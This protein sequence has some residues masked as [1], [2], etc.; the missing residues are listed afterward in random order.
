MYDAVVIGAGPAGA[1]AAKTVAENGGRVL[2]LEKMK[3]PRVK[4]CSGVLIQKTLDLVSRLYGGEIPDSVQCVPA[5]QRGM[6]FF[7][8][9]GKEYRFEQPGLNIWRNSFDH[10]LVKQAVLAG[11]VLQENTTACT[12][13]PKNDTVK[14]DLPSSPS[15]YGKTVIICDGA[16]GSIGH[17]LR[18]TS[19]G[20]ITTF[21]TFYHGSIDLD[22]HYFYA[23]LQHEFS[24]YDAWVNMKDEYIIAGVAVTDN[25]RIQQYQ[26]A[27]I[28]YLTARYQFTIWRICQSEKW[29]MPHIQPGCPLHLGN[30]NILFA[31]EAAGFLNPMGEGMSCAL[32]SG[33][34]AGNAAISY[35]QNGGNLLNTYQDNIKSIHNYMVRQ[36]H[37]LSQI[38]TSFPD[39]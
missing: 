33:Y 20:H 5:D 2:L 21:Q 35:L 23:F 24:Q 26:T 38:S 22:P 36:W 6:V 10:W 39:M 27:F 13:I 25:S 17:K 9:Q 4:S 3:L 31:G 37:F 12:C 16:A 19:P 34:A 8:E 15:V 29:I 28:E 30:G 11:V 7:D 1:M 18:P 14:I 32:E